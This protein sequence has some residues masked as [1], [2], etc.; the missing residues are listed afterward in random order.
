MLVNAGIFVSITTAYT[1]EYIASTNMFERLARV[2]AA[3]VCAPAPLHDAPSPPPLL[4]I[5][6]FTRLCCTNPH[7]SPLLPTIC[8]FPLIN[9]SLLQGYDYL[10]AALGEGKPF[11]GLPNS[12]LQVW[13]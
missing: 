1:D 11:V 8:L 3:R 4:A 5:D 13:G 12:F 6:A 7:S 2:V 9:A 10:A